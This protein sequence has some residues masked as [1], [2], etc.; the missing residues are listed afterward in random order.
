M[1]CLRLALAVAAAGGAA[2][3]ALFRSPS[4]IATVGAFFHPAPV[5]CALLVLGY[6]AWSL[7]GT[8]DRIGGSTWHLLRPAPAVALRQIFLSTIDWLLTGVAL[9]V[10]LPASSAIAFGT[11]LRGYMVAQ[12]AGVTSHVPSGV[13]IGLAGAA[14]LSAP[15]SA[16]VH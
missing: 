13:A 16:H 10:L 1:I 2:A 9:Y 12:A 5:A 4:I 11:L 14:E 6:V 15:E 3:W 7:L 8:R